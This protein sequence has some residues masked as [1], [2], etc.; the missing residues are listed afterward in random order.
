LS[1]SRKSQK[2]DVVG[3]GLP[4]LDR[5]LSGGL[6]DGSVLVLMGEPGSGF[7][8]FA[9]QIMYLKAKEGSEKVAYF[10]VDRPSED[11]KS[12][13]SIYGWDLDALEK[14]D[15]WTFIDAYAPRQ[16]VRRGMTGRRIIIEMLATTLP[17]AIGEGRCSVVDT[18][19]YFLLFYDL[20]DI[21]DL[22]ETV[23]LQARK[24][25]GIHFFLVVSG[26]H[27]TKTIT[28]LVHF[29]DGM[30]EFNLNPEEE[31]AAG[32]IR[33]KKLRRIH[34]IVRNIPYRI[35]SDGIVIETTM[36]IA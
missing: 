18:F 19:S 1:S 10:S 15:V 27:D 32:T 20:K 31:E 28:T 36:R 7:D 5:I 29:T 23:I 30:L 8:L 9:Q 33:I 34:H 6:P 2:F 14:E 35:A 25:G 16:E 4:I 21:I 26:L 24:H 11:V 17:Q 22:V 3:T 13:M 12:E